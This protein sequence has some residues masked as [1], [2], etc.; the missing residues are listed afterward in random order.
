M[1]LCENACNTTIYTQNKSPHKILEDKTP[2]EAFTSV[3][4][5][6]RHLCILGYS[7]Y[8]PV[9]KERRTKMEPSNMK[10]MFGGYNETSKA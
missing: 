5:K 7:M 4:P 9:P 2:M 3:K 10:G 8:I 1:F 6:V